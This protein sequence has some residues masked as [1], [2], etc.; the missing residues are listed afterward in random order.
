MGV[1]QLELLD[2]FIAAKRRIAHTYDD[3][4]RDIPGIQPMREAEWAFSIF[5]MYTVL[6]DKQEYG[7]DSRELIRKLAEKNIQ[8]RPLW[9]PMHRSPA[10]QVC[11]SYKCEVADS[12]NQT[13]ISIPCSVGLTEEQQQKVIDV[14][15]SL[16]S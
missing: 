10:M 8:A 11:Q 5:W 4:L 15:Q 6:V 14:I 12:L 9:Q 1:A 3:A 13:A 7:L 2:E 16:R